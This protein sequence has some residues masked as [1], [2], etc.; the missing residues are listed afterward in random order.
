MPLLPSGR[1]ISIDFT[2]LYE[3]EQRAHASGDAALLLF[4]DGD[5]EIF[6]MV[7]VDEVEWCGGV[8]EAEL[9]EFETAS[10]VRHGIGHFT[11]FSVSDVIAGRVPWSRLDID[12]FRRFVES[13]RIC[14]QVR[15]FRSRCLSLRAWLTDRV[16]MWPSSCQ[17][18]PLPARRDARAVSRSGLEEV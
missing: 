6:S 11:G 10:G 4:L 12:A 2:P 17:A 16:I 15:L 8:P 5:E 1:D 14:E 3:L 18:L 7:L 9:D 13:P